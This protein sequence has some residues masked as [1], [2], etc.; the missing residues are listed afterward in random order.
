MIKEGLLQDCMIKDVQWNS[1]QTRAQLLQSQIKMTVGLL[2]IRPNNF[3]Y[4]KFQIHRCLLL[5]YSELLGHIWR[6][7]EYFSQGQ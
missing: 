3:L 2:Q 6:R 7:F 5:L 1:D 4:E